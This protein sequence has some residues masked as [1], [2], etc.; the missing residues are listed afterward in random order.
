MYKVLIADDERSVIDG[1]LEAIDW[2]AM[3]MD[4]AATAANG[5]EAVA[6]V[7]EWDID[8]A[9][10]DIRMP[11]MNGLEACAAL[12]KAHENLQIIIV[13]G[14]AEFSYAERAIEYGVIG[15]CLKPLEYDKVRKCLVKAAA[16]LDRTAGD[17]SSVDLLDAIDTDDTERIAAMLERLGMPEPRC[18]LTV[19]VGGERLAL[20][21]P[22]LVLETGRNLCCYL[23]NAPFQRDVLEAYLSREENSGVGVVAGKVPVDAL[24]REMKRCTVQAYQFFFA[25]RPA[26]CDFFHEKQANAL[27]QTISE[28][29]ARERWD[30]VQMQLR[31]I[32]QRHRGDFNIRTAQKLCNAIHV[33]SLF[34]ETETDYYIYDY[35]QVV[36]E[37]S[38][39]SQMLRRLGEDIR[40]AQSGADA[41]E[42]TNTAFMKLLAY[43]GANYKKDIS[44]TS[45]GEA[46]HMNPNYVSQLF[47]KESGETFIHYITQLRMDDAVR[48]LTTTNMPVV[49][50]AVEVG[51][52]DYFYFL[53]TFK[54]VMKRTP[55]QYRQ[56]EA[57][58]A[59]S[60]R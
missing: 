27:I 21:G 35:R 59:G 10:L 13:S 52:N 37:Y 44:L 50:I 46:L 6:A 55:S 17:V 54:R 36:T 30:L 23:T 22:G 47:K 19:T 9:I 7:R 58:M 3:G 24:K 49:D 39:F 5:R 32:E 15:Y 60:A 38:S 43:I 12:R 26:L 1:L 14:Y 29:V 51:F 25:E 11:G 33:G 28:S 31:T 48:L 34:R 41:G 56:E 45:A 4:V 57:G 8:I 18:H 20:S 53:K 40:E 42:Y 2:S 16:N